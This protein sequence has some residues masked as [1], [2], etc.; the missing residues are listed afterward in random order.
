MIDGLSQLAWREPLWLWMAL[1]PWVL[2]AL[3]WGMALPAG[4]QYADPGLLPWV[5]ARTM[6]DTGLRRLWRPA[7]LALAWI[8][9]A[10]AM[11]G[12]RL[13]EIHHDR[14]KDS[15]TELMVVVDA[16]Y[17]MTARD[18]EPG[19]LE[20]AKLELHDLVER[21]ERLKI[22]LVVYAA[23]PHLLNPPTDDKSILRHNLQLLRH[24]LL[25]TE[26]SGLRDAMEFAA[27]HFSANEAARAML[28]V[29]DG[30][31]SEGDALAGVAL[32]DTATRLGQQG[33][34]L[35]AL[36]IGSPEGAALLAREGGWLRHAGEAVVTRLQEDR[37]KALAALGN[38]RYARVADSDSE[39]RS[40]YDQGIAG[41]A[42]V[43]ADRDGD[44]LVVWNELYGWCL[45]PAVLLMLLAQVA[46]R[47][48]A[49]A[50]A[51]MLVVVVSLYGWLDP[52]V[53]YAADQPR[54][55]DAFQAYGSESY[56]E[57]RQAYAGI[58]GYAGRMGEGS[59]AYRQG[60]YRAAVQL[61]TQAV[62]DA[63]SDARRADAVFNLANSHYKL[64]DHDTAVALYQ[65]VLRY[66]AGRQAARLNLAL[67]VAMRDR[68]QDG[69][70]PAA[71]ARQGRGPRSARLADGTGITRGGLILDEQE[72]GRPVFVPDLPEG[73]PL[74]ESE[75]IELGIHH[76][77]S[78][79]QQEDEFKD[80]GWDYA[81][82]TTERILLQANALKVD[83]AILWKRIFETEE[84][85]P[86]PVE[87]PYVLPDVPPW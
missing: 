84:G 49:S 36:G 44:R 71:S 51:P 18:V 66:D 87:T 56:Q 77:R 35:H 58:P 10:M 37:L 20:R 4:R 22:G 64:E 75:L 63:D 34:V 74:S 55:Q 48:V 24:G 25:P 39:W 70:V 61:F 30:E 29:T 11:A 32:D 69:D 42:S 16:S 78:V 80:P 2:W 40:L 83:E 15:Y 43:A 76:S 50:M 54:R 46:P 68:R 62:L 23:R 41:L 81:V 5:C 7:M 6:R 73:R 12:P 14:N 59:S 86:A 72:A 67:A 33:I 1:Y 17:S 65:E 47:R 53:V 38:G 85:F 45:L 27:T 21:A 60:D 3:R 28:L 8:L 13:A 31:F 52:G 19:R 9:F 79:V 57:A 26:G 82:T